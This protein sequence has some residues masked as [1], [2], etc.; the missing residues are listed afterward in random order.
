MFW[1]PDRVESWK[2]EIVGL[3]ERCE[4]MITLSKDAHELWGEARFA[5]RPLQLVNAR[6]L[7]VQFFWQQKA[8]NSIDEVDLLKEPMSSEGLKKSNGM[9]MPL[10]TSEGEGDRDSPQYEPIRSGYEFD[11]VTEDPKNFPLPSWQLLEM[12]WHLQRVAAMSGAGEA[13]DLSSL[14]DDYFTGGNIA[15]S[16][17]MFNVLKWLQVLPVA[18]EKNQVSS[19]STF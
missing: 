11:I 13:K 14:D 6:T 3:R 12:Q 5:L 15:N 1:T 4:N 17:T 7:R 18:R 9:H 19:I 8:N 2:R 10:T 16:A